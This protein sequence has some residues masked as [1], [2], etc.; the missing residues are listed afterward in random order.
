MKLMSKYSL[1]REE[2]QYRE[3]DKSF[4]ATEARMSNSSTSPW[5][6]IAGVV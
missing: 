1:C 5:S 3:T 2:L 6:D 4:G